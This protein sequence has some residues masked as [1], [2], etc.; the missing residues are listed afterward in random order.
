[1]IEIDESFDVPF[2]PATVWT[3]IRDPHAVVGCVAGAELGEEYEDG[4]FAGILT[5]KFGALQVKFT[6]RITLELDEE[7]LRG[8]LVAQG[9]DAQGG[10]RVKTTA[11]FLV[12]EGPAGEGSTVTMTG[13]VELSGKLA[14]VIEAGATVVVRRLT[15][16]FAENLTARCAGDT[17][18]EG[19]PGTLF[20]WLRSLFR[21]KTR[22]QP[23]QRS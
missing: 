8:R 19:T 16:E 15:N 21:P 6:N 4:S 14:S 17:A 10:A 7:E 11:D 9:K 22:R 2:P 13:L 12:A 20:A 3:V 5:V 18:P 23:D 1:M